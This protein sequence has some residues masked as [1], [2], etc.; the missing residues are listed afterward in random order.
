MEGEYKG[1]SRSPLLK[2]PQILKQFNYLAQVVKNAEKRIGYAVAHDPD[3]VN[4]IS[5][6]EKF[7]RKKRRVCYGGQAI[8]SILP[9]NK[10]FYDDSVTVPDYDFFSPTM[11][12][13]V[14]ELIEMLQK[15]GFEDVNKK[16]SMH[17][18]TT[19]IYVNFI[20]VADISEFNPRMFTIIQK[21]AKAVDGILYCDEDFLR[22]MMYLE[23]S[24]PR[25]EVERW[26]KVFER[27]TLLNTEY[28]MKDCDEEIKV[29][30]AVPNG[31]RKSIL[32]FC[33]KHKRVVMGPE[34]IDLLDTNKSKTHLE[35]LVQRGGPVIFFSNKFES[36]GEDLQDIL[37]ENKVSVKLHL[38]K[39]ADD[40]S[41]S[42]ISLT[43]RGVPVCLI[44]EE[45][46][47]HTYTILNLDIGEMRIGLPDLY[48][49]LYFSL[50]LFA[51]KEKAFFETSL[52]CLVKKLYRISE[53]HRINPTAFVPAFG[54]RC[55][56]H[57][58]GIATLMK[59]RAQR[60]NKVKKDQKDQ[61]DQKA[62]TTT[63]KLR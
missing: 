15:E 35:T 60:T 63:R 9:K 4:A 27:L 26:K 10:K 39:T 31:V 7:L 47:C 51:K 34:F 49:H 12:S 17:E 42:Y 25:G 37:R 1:V 14:D 36:D 59:A 11:N 40:H 22:M 16:L 30:E 8:N 33:Q 62:K 23:L 2:K 18:G 53:E 46:S 57:Q 32:T 29:S 5:I 50:L 6:V 55:S 61:K 56:G 44:F 58:K 48:L 20:P 54:L 19:K 38:E 45:D 52:D 28:P 43:S 41:F 21:R 3:I 13:D 24:R